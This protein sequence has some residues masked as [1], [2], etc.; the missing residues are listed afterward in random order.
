MKKL[1]RCAVLL[2][3]AT[4]SPFGATLAYADGAPKPDTVLPP[5]LPPGCFIVA[6]NMFCVDMPLE[7]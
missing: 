7:P 2:A 4:S 1:A 3:I 5:P 6:G